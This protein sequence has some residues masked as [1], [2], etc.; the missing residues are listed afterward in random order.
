MPMTIS[1]KMQQ[2]NLYADSMIKSV[3]N[4]SPDMKKNI[5]KFLVYANNN[6]LQG[7]ALVAYHTAMNNIFENKDSFS[8]EGKKRIVN[9]PEYYENVINRSSIL[10]NNSEK[11][12]NQINKNY[13]RSI[14]SRVH[15]ASK[16]AVTSNE[17]KPQSKLKKFMVILSKLFGED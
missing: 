13:P 14:E 12:L 3:V 11:F 10:K 4:N 17:I 8:K 6:N 1:P 9:F 2:L 15:L 16:G 5:N 7:P